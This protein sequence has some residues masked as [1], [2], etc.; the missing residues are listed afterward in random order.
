[1]IQDIAQ[2]QLFSFPLTSDLCEKAVSPQLSKD[3]IPENPE[4]C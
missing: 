1:M 4:H 2:L 3:A